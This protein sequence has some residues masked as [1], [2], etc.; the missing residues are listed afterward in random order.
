MKSEKFRRHINTQN[1]NCLFHANFSVY[2]LNLL[3]G[4]HN[5]SDFAALINSQS[6]KTS[7]YIAFSRQ[8]IIHSKSK[9]PK[10]N[11]I[12]QKHKKN[13]LRKKGNF[14]FFC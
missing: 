1:C 9:T 4:K 13:I 14:P 12:K 10:N 2:F 3:D 5:F 6:W 11:K 8:E 7:N